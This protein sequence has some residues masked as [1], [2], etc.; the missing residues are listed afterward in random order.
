MR[1]LFIALLTALAGGF[2]GAVLGDIATRALEVTDFEGARGYAVVFICIP[3]GLIVGA[4]VGV[5]VSRSLGPAAAWWKAQ[6]IALLVTGAIGGG[7]TGFLVLTAPRAPTIDGKELDLAIEIRMPPG[8]TAPDSGTYGGF[9]AVLVSNGN[10]KR[11]VGAQLDFS[12]VS[13]SEGRVVIPGTVWLRETTRIRSLAIN[14]SSDGYWFDLPLQ[15]KPDS[16]DMHWSDWFPAPGQRASTDVR[17]T[18]GFQVRWRV[19]VAPFRG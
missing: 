1:I 10:S 18:N 6:G 8:R 7:I 5:V 12:A 19:T 16:S 17:G 3:L 13:E 2:L 14:D 9:S 11:R 15:A 4:I